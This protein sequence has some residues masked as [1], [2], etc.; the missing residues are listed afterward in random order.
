MSLVAKISP[1]LLLIQS[2][3]NTEGMLYYGD[4]GE[5]SSLVGC[6]C[7]KSPQ[8]ELGPSLKGVSLFSVV[9]VKLCGTDGSCKAAAAAAEGGKGSG[10]RGC[11][12]LGLVG[13]GGDLLPPGGGGVD[14]GLTEAPR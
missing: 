13:G 9:A 5:M 4:L 10:N 8:G 1:P 14:T 11:L 7:F 2:F 12:V 3:L 6:S